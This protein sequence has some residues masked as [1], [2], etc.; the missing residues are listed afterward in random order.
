[1]KPS[2]IKNTPKFQVRAS[3]IRTNK[4][5]GKKKGVEK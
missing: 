1:M 5:K 2:Q 3:C 4:D